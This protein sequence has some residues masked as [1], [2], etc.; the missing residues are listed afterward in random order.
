MTWNLH[1][2][3]PARKALETFPA[4]DQRFILS[5]LQAMRTDPFSGNIKRLKNERSTWRRRVGNYRIFFDVY[6][7][8]LTVDVVEIARRTSTTY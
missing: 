8:S 6:P 5:A 4:K 3:G 2:A 7:T 1:I